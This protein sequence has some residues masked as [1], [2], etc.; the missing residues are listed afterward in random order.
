MEERVAAIADGRAR[1]LRWLVGR[2][3]D[4]H[5]GRRAPRTAMFG[6]ALSG[7]QLGA[8]G[9]SPCCSGPGRGSAMWMLDYSPPAP[10]GGDVRAFVR[11]LKDHPAPGAVQHEGER[12]EGRVEFGLRGPAGVKTRL[13]RSAFVSVT[14]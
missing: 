6:R 13:L 4:L 8:A 3:A 14:G 9:N 7:L 5:G 1:E 2:T 10:G 12:R 11:D